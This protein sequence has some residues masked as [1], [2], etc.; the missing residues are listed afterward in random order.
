MSAHGSIA[1]QNLRFYEQGFYTAPSGRRV[2]LRAL[3]DAACEGTRVYT[4]EALEA[5]E[6]PA[7]A[8][9]RRASVWVSDEDSGTAAQSMAREGEVALLNFASAKNPGGG[10]LTG[11]KA[12]EEDLARA[13]G[14]YPCL[15][16]ASAYYAAN[17]ACGTA[18]YTDHLVYSPRVPFFRS[19]DGR[20]LEEP[21]VAS[22]LTAPAPNRGV[23]EQRRSRELDAVRDTL[24]RRTGQVLDVAA[25]H[26]HRD[27]V[28]GAW[29][30]GV[31]RNDPAEVALC[32]DSALRSREGHF[33]RVCMAIL[34]KP[35]GANRQAFERQFGKGAG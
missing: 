34:G 26:G 7:P 15:L 3:L 32:W 5:L 29:G 8:N 12:Q 30:C 20:L 19:R 23:L 6:V 10:F 18:L 14:L 13:S 16:R 35:G 27:L 21:F 25:R 1:E 2:E 24:A 28:L 11:A 17:R 33:G 4:P 31:F 22:V 9:P